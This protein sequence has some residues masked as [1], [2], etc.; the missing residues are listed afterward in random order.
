[1]TSGH[2]EQMNEGGGAGDLLEVKALE[3]SLDEQSAASQ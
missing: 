2:Q 3:L 1:M